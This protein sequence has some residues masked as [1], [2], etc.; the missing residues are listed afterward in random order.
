MLLVEH[1][2]ILIFADFVPTVHADA[3]TGVHADPS[4]RIMAFGDI[5]YLGICAEILNL[6]AQPFFAEE[7]LAS[8]EI[9]CCLLFSN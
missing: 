3:Y 8:Q 5:S 4:A 9:I 1:D 7:Q 6:K 2:E